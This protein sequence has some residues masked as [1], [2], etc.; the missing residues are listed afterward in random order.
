MYF[1][2]LGFFTAAMRKI[3]RNWTCRLFMGFI[4][5]GIDFYFDHLRHIVVF[6]NRVEIDM[7]AQR[8]G[9]ESVAFCGSE[10]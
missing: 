7:A 9:I 10:A 6:G 5:Y 8:K 1:S 2:L 4:Y 3:V